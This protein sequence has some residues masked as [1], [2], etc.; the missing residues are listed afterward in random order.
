MAK[1]TT[2]KRKKLPA[3]KFALAKERKY[4]IH[5]KMHAI[6]AKARA[7]HQLDMGNLSKSKYDEIIK[8]AN[9]VLNKK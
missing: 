6:N 9:K 3:K 1:L 2:K 4:P 8:E 5:D 7:K